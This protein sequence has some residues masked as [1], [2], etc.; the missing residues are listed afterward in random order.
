MHVELSSG[1]LGSAG[2]LL[3]VS[4]WNDAQ[5]CVSV[6]RFRDGRLARLP[7]RDERARELPDC[8]AFGDW[9]YRFESPGEGRPA[10]LVRERTTKSAQGALRIREVFA[11]AGFSLDADPRRSSRE[12]EGIPIPAWRGDILYSNEALETLYDRFDLSRMRQ[13]PT[14]RIVADREHGIFSLRFE[15]PEGDT[16]DAPVDSYAARGREIALGARAGDRTARVTVRLGG[17]DGKA[18][19]EVEVDGLG[20]PLDREYGPAGTLHGRAPELFAS[21]ADELASRELSGTWIDLKGGGATTLELE[22]ASSPYRL[23][24][25]SD[26]YAVDLTRAERPADVVLIPQT[27]SGRAWGI[28]LRGQNVLERTAVACPADG[29]PCRAE[30]PPER[31]RRLGA[32]SNA[33]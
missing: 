14:L 27:A 7:I 12:I 20:A 32:R 24:I 28:V 1:S 5:A 15:K 29:S 4:A 31:L 11:F 2:A 19:V 8:A 22:A 9:S 21:A 3:E 13:D 25:G 10:E 17:P 26:L 18:P 16:L 30:G 33:P 23:R 6:W